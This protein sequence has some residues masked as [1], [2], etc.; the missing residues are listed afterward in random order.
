MTTDYNKWIDLINDSVKLLVDAGIEGAA[1]EVQQ[2]ICHVFSMSLSDFLL[3]KRESLNEKAKGLLA[4]YLS[5]LEKRASRVPLS[6][7]IGERDFCGFTFKVNEHVLTPR[8]ETEELVERVVKESKDADVLDLCTGS[9]CIAISIALLGKPK[10]VTA[11]DISE[12]ALKVAKENA[13]RL[14]DDSS[15]INILQGDLFENVNGRFDIIVS[16][17]PYIK[18][19]DVLELDIEVK[20]HEPILALDGGTDGLDIYK[21][22]ISEAPKYIKEK[23]RIFFEIGYDEGPEVKKLLEDAGFTDCKVIKD[24]S[25]RDRIVCGALA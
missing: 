15:R 21:R 23:G 6:Q 18:S 9:G 14:L 12:D 25:G 8:F 7:V 4:E 22:I 16:N 24:L 5:L 17:P 3:C 19:A 10:S 1:V 2:L 11:S 13:A 20:D